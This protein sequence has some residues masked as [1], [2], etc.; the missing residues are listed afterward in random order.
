[1]NVAIK[2]PNLLQHRV[3]CFPML[4]Q[5]YKYLSEKLEEGEILNIHL[6][7]IKSDIEVLNL[8]PFHAYYHELELGDLKNVFT[9]HRACTQ[10][11]M[12][13]NLDLYISTTESF[14]DASFGFLLKAKKKLGF[15]IPRNSI[16]LNSYIS[17]EPLSDIYIDK[18]Y[19]LLDG[20]MLDGDTVP[21]MRS[22]IS[23]EIDPLF[24]SHTQTYIVIDLPLVKG[25]I[26][27]EWKDLFSLCVGIEF[28]LMCSKLDPINAKIELKQYIEALAPQNN[29][30]IFEHN[31]KIDF[32]KLCKGA[33]YF[34]GNW[35]DYSL[36]NNY[37]SGTNLLTS[38]TYPQKE[39]E[40]FVG[41]NIEVVAP[42]VSKGSDKYYNYIFD[43]IIT[44]VESIPKEIKND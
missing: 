42:G 25:E 17:P 37:I 21:K 43:N 41:K 2:L 34:I 6:F 15:K 16:F 31:S 9:A 32:A 14:V 26:D 28:V 18:I 4:H 22:I 5:L 20:V 7:S 1:M 38:N 44:K 11:R 33:S 35:S 19:T 24:K 40:C 27:P 3:L 30:K 23:R 8:L 10:I 13:L 12:E 36:I 39:L 29:Y